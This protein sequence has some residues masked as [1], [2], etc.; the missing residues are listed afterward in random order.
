MSRLLS[1]IFFARAAA[2]SSP[3]PPPPPPFLR[4]ATSSSTASSSSSAYSTE[5][6]QL[7]G[8]GAS[9]KAIRR[10]ARQQREEQRGPDDLVT[11]PPTKTAEEL[12]RMPYVVRRTPSCQPPVY[13]DVRSGGTRKVVLIKK[14]EGDKQ[15]MVRDLVEHLK[16]DREK[17]RINPITEHVEVKGDLL[18]PVK[19]WLL[20]SG[21]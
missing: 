1:R 8:P 3:R 18:R 4:I 5:A 17:V 20:G 7:D 21:F 15:Q 2:L 12:A 16:I 9:P 6:W 19:Q 10:R 11:P 14:I 13:R